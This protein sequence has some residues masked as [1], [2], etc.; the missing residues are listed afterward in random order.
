MARCGIAR[1]GVV[2]HVMAGKAWPGKD[3]HGSVGYAV[4]GWA[5]R[6]GVWRVMVWTG[7]TRH[8]KKT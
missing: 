2:T 7:K 1:W 5:R 4:A 6:G 8:G 3:R